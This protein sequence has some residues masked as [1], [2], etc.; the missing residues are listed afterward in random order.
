GCEHMFGLAG[1]A[2]GEYWVVF[3][4]PEFV[5]AIWPA[6]IGESLHRVP[7]RRIGLAAKIAHQHR[8]Q[9]GWIGRWRDQT[10]H[11]TSGCPRRASWAVSYWLRSLAWK[12]MRTET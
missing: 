9:R 10:V 8:A 11:F 3:H 6:R 7:H 5:V 4:Q 2:L 12:A 1:L